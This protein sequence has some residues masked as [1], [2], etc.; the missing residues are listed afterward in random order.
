MRVVI[1]GATGPT[2]RQLVSQ[3]LET[4]YEISAIVRDPAKL[5]T[6]HERLKV[7]SG[8]IFDNNLLPA[9]FKNHDAVLSALGVGTTLK[10]HHLME[11]AMRVIIPAMNH[12]GLKRIIYMSAFGVGDSFSES[13]FIQKL[14]FRIFLKSIYADKI[15]ADEL[16]SASGLEWTMVRPVMLTNGALTRKYRAAEKIKMNWMPTISRADVAHFMVHEVQENKWIR[17]K[18]ILSP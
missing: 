17:K 2:G 6:E 11:N 10:S 14:A 8:D 5:K 18:V 3:A 16:V 1:L 9:V 7:L 15:I 4:G 12:A 13:S